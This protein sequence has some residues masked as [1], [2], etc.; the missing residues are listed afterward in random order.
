MT[1]ILVP[2]ATNGGTM[3]RTPFDSSAGFYDEAAV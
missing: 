1:T 3:V 2:V